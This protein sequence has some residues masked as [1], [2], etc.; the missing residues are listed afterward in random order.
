MQS[1]HLLAELLQ[2]ANARC[3]SCEVEDKA[4]DRRRARV[5]SR[6]PNYHLLIERGYFSLIDRCARALQPAVDRRDV[7]VG[8]R[9]RT[10]R[11]AIGVVLTGANA[12]GAQACSA[13]PTA[14]ATRSCRIPATA[15]S[16][17]D[18]ARRAARRARGACRCRSSGSR[19]PRRRSRRHDRR[20]EQRVGAPLT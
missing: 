13:S 11:R 4:A 2:D 14:A 5:T 7:R 12:D 18:A 17:D 6:P 20:R 1:G 16:A 3:A 8:G 15:E 19:A 10:A 9:R